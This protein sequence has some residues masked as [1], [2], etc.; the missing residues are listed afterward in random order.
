MYVNLNSLLKQYYRL[1][2]KQGWYDEKK[3]DMMI[4]KDWFCKNILIKLSD[5][6]KNN[7]TKTDF[8]R[9]LR[10]SQRK[11]SNPAIL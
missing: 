8:S 7:W 1:H 10:I 9:R 5:L 6:D 2:H 11:V 3:V 4:K